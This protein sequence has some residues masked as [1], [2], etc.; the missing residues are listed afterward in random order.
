MDKKLEKKCVGYDNL[1]TFLFKSGFKAAID[2]LRDNEYYGHYGH[3]AQSL[4]DW[5][6]LHLEQEVTSDKAKGK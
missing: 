5:L 1:E 6:E 4:A 3:Y 2:V